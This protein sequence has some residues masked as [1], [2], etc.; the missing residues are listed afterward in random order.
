[1]VIGKYGLLVFKNSIS[2]KCRNADSLLQ[3]VKIGEITK[4]NEKNPIGIFVFS[5]LR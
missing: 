1:M 5:C 2:I 3:T 4:T